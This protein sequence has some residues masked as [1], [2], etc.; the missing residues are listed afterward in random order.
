VNFLDEAL[1]F[2]NHQPLDREGGVFGLGLD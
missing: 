1:D 2:E